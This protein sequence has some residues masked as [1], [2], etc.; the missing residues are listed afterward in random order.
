[1]WANNQALILSLLPALQALQPAPAPAPAPAPPPVKEGDARAPTNLNGEDPAKIRDFLFECGL[2]FNMK[3]H[4]YATERSRVL[5]AIQHLDGIAKRHFRRYIELGST[6]PKVTQ[7]ASFVQELETVFGDPD[8]IGRASDKLLKLKMK[9]SD[10]VHKFTIR[11]KELADEVSWPN[12]VLHHLYYNALPNR[13]KDLWARSDPP[14]LLE[15][16][17]REAQRADNRY[18]KRVEEKKS[19]TTPARTSEQKSQPNTPNS[20][21]PKSKSTSQ[22]QSRSSAS[23]QSTS[24]SNSR[25]TQTPTAKTKDLSKILGPDGK[26][27]PEEKARREKLGLCT[28]CA[29]KHATDICPSKPA[30]STPKEGTSSDKPSTPSKSTS[31]SS[32]GSKPKGR[33]VQ[34]TNPIASDSNTGDD[35][36]PDF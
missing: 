23:A 6:D 29:E 18:W 25:S 14:P 8:C 7:W 36:D 24:S 3:P 2:I 32:N 33:V 10:H 11:F 35:A 28:Y 20:Q 34:V 27:L 31:N 30:S 17:M 9:E 13:I 19:E 15:D 26:L 5:Y 21:Q 16:L 1:M 4:T 22:S 12:P